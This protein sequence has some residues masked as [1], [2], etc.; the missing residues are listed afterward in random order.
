MRM[1]SNDWDPPNEFFAPD[2]HKGEITSMT[3]TDKIQ[4]NDGAAYE[5]YM[6]VWSRLVGEAFLDWLAPAPG[7]KWLDVGCG[8][9]AFTQ[10]ILQRCA[11]SGVDGIDPSEAQLAFAGSQP[12]LAKARFQK[13]DAMAL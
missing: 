10:M 1:R 11:P 12:A 9:G 3:T 5:R 2:I 13:G 8:N 6:G 4:F 7:G